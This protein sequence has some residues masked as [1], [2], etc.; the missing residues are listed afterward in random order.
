M[1]TLASIKKWKLNNPDKVKAQKA[2]RRGKYKNSGKLKE[3]QRQYRL[4]KKAKWM[5]IIEARGMNKCQRC[6]YDKFFGAIDF[7]HTQPEEKELEP[8][9]MLSKSVTAKRLTELDKCIALCANC[10]R[11]LHNEM[12]G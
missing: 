5:E 9:Q 2:R 6:G 4:R 10:H 7:H 12:R 8:C 1:T 11:E 3:E